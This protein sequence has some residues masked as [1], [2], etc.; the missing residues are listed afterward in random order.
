MFSATSTLG[1][2]WQHLNHSYLLVRSVYRFDLY[3]H[4]RL[5]LHH[6]GISLPHEEGFSK[7]KSSYIKSTY[8]NICDDY[9]VNG[10]E[11]WMHGNW[12]YTTKYGIFGHGRKAT[13]ISPPDNLTQ[14]IIAQSKG[15]TRKSI[16]K[17]RRSV[18]ANVYLVLRSQV[19]GRS[20]IV[21]NSASAVDA[22]QNFKSTFKALINQNHSISSD[23]DRYQSVLENALSNV[24]FSVG[25]G[26]YMLLSNL[27][28]SIEKM[29]GYRH[30]N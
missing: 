25:T 24:D 10:D 9:G 5:I 15:F 6:L 11:T 17:I 22:Q 28:L 21:G 14:W 30:E 19:Q 26:I 1:I 16:E 4:V 8:L 13:K 3:I 29:I 7:L 12:F 18:R 27:S 23:I 2:S 20:R